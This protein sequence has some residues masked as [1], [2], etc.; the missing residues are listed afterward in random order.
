LPQP[1][2][3]VTSRASTHARKTVDEAVRAPLADEADRI[4]ND[5]RTLRGSFACGG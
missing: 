5:A 2:T 3:I 1:N 4:Q